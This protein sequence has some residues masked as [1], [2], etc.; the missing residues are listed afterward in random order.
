M[1]GPMSMMHGTP[2]RRQ[3]QICTYARSGESGRHFWLV[4]GADQRV[5]RALIDVIG[6]REMAVG[7]EPAHQSRKTATLTEGLAHDVSI[8]LGVGRQLGWQPRA[9][10]SMTIMRAPQHG[11]GYGSTRVACGATSGCCWGSAAGG[12]TSRSARAIA[13][14]WARLVEANSP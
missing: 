6:L 1:R 12:T 2:G 10:T 11:H 9:N 13:I 14:L 5:I 3:L 8:L 4:F 7:V